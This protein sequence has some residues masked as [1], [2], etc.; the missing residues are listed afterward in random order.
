MKHVQQLVVLPLEK[1][2]R[3]TAFKNKAQNKTLETDLNPEETYDTVDGSIT[4]VNAENDS[5]SSSSPVEPSTDT[6][7]VLSSLKVLPNNLDIDVDAAEGK[8]HR[9]P[10]GK[11]VK[12]ERSSLRIKK[13][14]LLKGKWLKY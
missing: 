10:P 11:P 6:Q 5:R 2:E 13:E 7:T 14:S 3:L 9:P 8:I 12:R 4:T 1:Y